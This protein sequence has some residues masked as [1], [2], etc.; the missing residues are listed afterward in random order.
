[1]KLIFITGATIFLLS[2]LSTSGRA[3]EVRH[4]EMELITTDQGEELVVEIATQQP[5]DPTLYEVKEEEGPKGQPIYV[6]Y[7][8]PTGEFVIF[9]NRTTIR[10]KAEGPGV[11]LFQTRVKPAIEKVIGQKTYERDIKKRYLDIV[12]PD[13]EKVAEKQA[14]DKD[15]IDKVIKRKRN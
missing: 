10:G 9:F 8:I 2:I 4:P 11:S 5:P 7:Y 1:M 12:F 14:V 15:D 6:V 3:Q 13:K